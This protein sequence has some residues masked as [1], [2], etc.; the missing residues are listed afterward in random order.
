MHFRQ[1][2]Q[3]QD[4]L[5]SFFRA[6]FA[7]TPVLPDSLFKPAP[8]P[9]CEARK[10]NEGGKTHL[11]H[12]KALRAK[13]GKPGSPGEDER[14][15]AQKGHGCGLEKP[16]QAGVH[17]QERPKAHSGPGK[18]VPKDDTARLD[19]GRLVTQGRRHARKRQGS[20]DYHQGRGDLS[21]Y[22][23]PSLL[24]GP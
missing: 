8:Q 4:F 2:R 19:V 3:A 16:P 5:F 18:D 15:K 23:Q 12:A 6:A 24:S 13:G 21:F 14:A 1:F 22:Q 9:G 20:A 17:Y 11:E 10:R 7:V